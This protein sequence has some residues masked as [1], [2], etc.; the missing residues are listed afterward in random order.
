MHVQSIAVGRVK[1]GPNYV[2]QGV[3]TIFDEG[4]QA[5]A[6]ATVYVLATGP[7]GGSYSGVTGANG[8]VTFETAGIKRPSGEW[9][10]EVTNVTH[11]SYTYN[12]AANLVTKACESGVVYGEGDELRA[13]VP[14]DFGLDQNYPNPFNPTT[15]IS[16]SLPQ[17]GAVSLDVYNVT[18]QHVATL[19]EGNLGAGYHTATWDATAYSSG[20]YFY[21]LVSTSG[22]AT[23]KMILLK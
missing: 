14:D 8:S 12:S 18:G 9:C 1:V 3:V 4:S 19:V 21:R 13:L 6:G 10:F 15:E 5:V 22:V 23:R 2:G 20:V 7:T 17:A 16:F 11:S